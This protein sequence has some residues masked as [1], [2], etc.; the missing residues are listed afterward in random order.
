MYDKQLSR[1]GSSPLD[2]DIR[3]PQKYHTD[4]T[5]VTE[6]YNLLL[7]PWSALRCECLCVWEKETTFAAELIQCEAA[8]M[9]AS[10]QMLSCAAMLSASA[11]QNTWNNKWPQQQLP[12]GSPPLL[13]VRVHTFTDTCQLYHRYKTGNRP[14]K[15]RGTCED[16]AWIPI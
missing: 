3:F 13:F 15:H 16:P 8:L 10:R 4:D 11:R 9:R 1:G 7:S 6:A 2:N 14:H 5:L 12:R